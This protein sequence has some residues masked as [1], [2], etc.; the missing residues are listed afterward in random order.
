MYEVRCIAQACAS[1]SMIGGCRALLIW[2]FVATTPSCL[3]WAASGM[4]TQ[5]ARKRR[6]LAVGTPR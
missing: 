6:A 4:A 5:G 3:A 2:S 1:V